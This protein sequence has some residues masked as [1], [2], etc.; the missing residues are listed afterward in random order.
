[1]W[2]AGLGD[3][4]AGEDIVVIEWA[5]RLPDLLPAERLQIHFEYL[6]E[7]RRRL[8]LSALGAHYAALLDALR[9]RI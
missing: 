5:D 6:D 2:D 9:Q 4:M 8:T 7:H 1:M 3:L